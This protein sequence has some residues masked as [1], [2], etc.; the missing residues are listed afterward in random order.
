MYNNII[1]NKTL[2]S[3]ST[4]KDIDMYSYEYMEDNLDARSHAYTKLSLIKR[5]SFIHYTFKLN[6]LQ[7]NTIHDWS[8]HLPTL[9][10]QSKNIIMNINI[11]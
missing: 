8:V 7:R 11:Q 10:L 6:R 9:E 5:S 2:E 1:V 4:F 3:V